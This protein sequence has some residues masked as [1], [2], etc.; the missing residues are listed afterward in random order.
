MPV[1]M[2][3]M[4]LPESGIADGIDREP[5]IFRTLV[6]RAILLDVDGTILDL[7]PAPHQVLV[8][9]GLRETLT[10]LHVATGG[11]LALVSG[12]TIDDLDRIFAPLQLSSVGGHGAEL[13]IGTEG[14]LK[15]VERLDDDLR[16]EL[17]AI[18]QPGNGVI[19]EDKGYSLALHFR[20][21][22]D[23][24]HRIRQ[25]IEQTC[26]KRRT[27]NVEILP[28]KS[29]FE[30]KCAGIS[31]ATGVR[32]LMRMAPFAGRCP[33]FI[34]DDKTDDS[35]FASL[36]AFG[37]LGYSVGKTVAGTCGRFDNPQAVRD[38]LARLAAAT[39]AGA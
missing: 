2:R 36:P 31:K 20:Q 28:G 22:P 38:W 1:M 5:P 37:G 27:S 30:I 32:A 24:E 29:V 25:W 4:V 13:R 6:G 10:A 11:A 39:R 33:I 34:G 15:L 18:A 23:W 17:S 35:V 12:R 8:P 21:A 7:A 26:D 16:T 3:H 9:A 14:R 19:A